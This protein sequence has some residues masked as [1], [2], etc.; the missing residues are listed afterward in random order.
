MSRTI[1]M[2][3]R[4]STFDCLAGNRLSR[5]LI[6]VVIFRKSRNNVIIYA[7]KCDVSVFSAELSD[8]MLLLT[9]GSTTCLPD[10]TA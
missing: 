4:A 6:I 8:S 5:T 7:Q 10:Y 3:V 1:S 9:I 2:S